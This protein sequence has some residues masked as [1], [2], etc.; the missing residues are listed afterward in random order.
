MLAI[1]FDWAFRERDPIFIVPF[2]RRRGWHTY[3]LEGS[4][5]LGCALL[6]RPKG[7]SPLLPPLSS[8]L[9]CIMVAIVSCFKFTIG[10]YCCHYLLLSL[11]LCAVAVFD[12]EPQQKS[13]SSCTSA[14]GPVYTVQFRILNAMCCV[15]CADQKYT[16]SAEPLS[17]LY[18]ILLPIST[19]T[20][21]R[22]LKVDI[23][24]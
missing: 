2:Y 16:H 14:K 24:H 11:W 15:Q 1:S 3:T 9:W 22:I 17:S 10:H 18:L 4:D 8:L 12:F 21:E 23:H 13:Q 5:I 7:K 20:R 6:W 19:T